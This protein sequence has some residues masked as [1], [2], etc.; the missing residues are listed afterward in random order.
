MTV[1][2]RPQMAQAHELATPKKY[3]ADFS[4]ALI[5]RTGAYYLSHDIVE[6]LSKYFPHIRYWRLLLKAPPRGIMRKFLARAML[7]ELDLLGTNERFPWP[8][9]NSYGRLPTLFFDPL[10]VSRARLRPDDIVLCH[11]VGPISH[12]E[13]FQAGTS[14]S[15]ER[16]YKKMSEVKPGVVFVSDASRRE[17]VKLVG[18]DFRFLHTIELYV[19]PSIVD[20]EMAPVPGVHAPFLLTVGA[21]E[22]R[23]NYLRVLEAYARTKLGERG[24]GYVFC[25]P[26]GVRADE[27]L[28]AAAEIPG[29]KALHYVSDSELNWLYANAV[30]FVLP[31]LLEGFGV[32]ALEAANAG[33]VP[34]VS[35]GGA[36]EEAINGHGVLV[37]PTSVESIAAG[38]VQLVEMSREERGALADAARRHAK[39]LSLERFLKQWDAV[40]MSNGEALVHR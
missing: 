16:A 8:D 6:N 25:G 35:R 31:S 37:D 27:V 18:E 1:E 14:K 20:G 5:N 32:P 24:I 36:Q 3:L 9:A 15:Y 30:G 26:R 23:K 4:L 22:I 28:S 39:T 2:K 10:Y 33:L 21:V 11:D 29:V 19:R 12:P 38:L 40:L 17:F 34:L 7:K 13:L